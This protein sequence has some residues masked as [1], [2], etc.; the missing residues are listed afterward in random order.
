MQPDQF[1]LPQQTDAVGREHRGVQ[2]SF[3]ESP[4]P[5]TALFEGIRRMV[6]GITSGQAPALNSRAAAARSGGNRA[7]PAQEAREAVS[8]IRMRS[9]AFLAPSFF[10]IL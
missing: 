8:T 2:D 9:A 7:D 6:R 5:A 4:H 10:M 1:G 3:E